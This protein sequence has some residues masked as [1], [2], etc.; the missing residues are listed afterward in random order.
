[1]LGEH[2]LSA[3]NWKMDGSQQCEYSEQQ[4]PSVHIQEEFDSD[5]LN[6]SSTAKVYSDREARPKLD[7]ELTEGQFLAKPEGGSI[8]PWNIVKSLQSHV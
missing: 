3:A 2:Q 1:M 7:D 5:I 6:G 4:S 8:H